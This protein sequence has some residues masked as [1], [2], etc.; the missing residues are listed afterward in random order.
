M[1]K[2]QTFEQFLSHTGE[3]VPVLAFLVNLLLAAVLAYI[4]SVVYTRY[5][6]ALSNRRL[7]SKNFLLITMTTMLIITIVKSSLALSL[8]LVGAL[9]IVRFRAAIKEPEELSYLFLTIA[10]GLGMGANQTIITLLGFLVI[11]SIIIVRKKNS[12]AFSQ[13]KNLH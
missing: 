2:L 8:G 7:S 4:L 10:V 13:N 11:V 12:S 1:N 5:G 3:N 9:S 6:H